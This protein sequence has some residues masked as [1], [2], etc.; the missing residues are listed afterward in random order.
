[1][2]FTSIYII[3]PEVFEMHEAHY[4]SREVSRMT[5]FRWMYKLGFKWSGSTSAPFC[6][7]HKDV[8]VSQQ[9]GKEDD[10][11]EITSSHPE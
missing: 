3:S 8:S 11:I 4:D 6:D 5:V 7:K 10:G 2:M 1:M 9:L